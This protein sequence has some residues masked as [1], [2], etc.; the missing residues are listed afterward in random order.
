M[1]TRRG[2]LAVLVGTAVVLAACSSS[3]TDVSGPSPTTGAGVATTSAAATGGPGTTAPRPLRILVSNDDGVGAPGID[4]LV[5]ALRKEPA[6]QVTVVAP[7]Q[8]QS[9][10]G[11]NTTPGTVAVSD[12]TT[13]SGYPAKSVAG[14]PA[15]A[16]DWALNGGIPDKPD[17]VITGSNAGQNL[18]PVVD[19]S[20]TV[21]AAR[22]GARAGIPAVAVSQGIANPI[23]YPSSVGFVIDWLRANRSSLGTGSSSSPTGVLNFNAPSCPPGTPVRGL[24]Q[25]PAATDASAGDG[26]TVN[27]ASTVTDVKNDV[28]AFDNGFA[29]QS[30][31][32]IEPG[33]K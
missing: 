13:A 31:L 14:F 8:N 4:A 24:K 32:P 30:V 11:G 33:S 15:D 12:A 6:V 20:G 2:L 18:G 9:G 17:L 27:C 1:R 21:G 16:V 19:L 23:D 25:V 5:E 29:S 10:T 28:E 7:A 26:G 3:S 22:A